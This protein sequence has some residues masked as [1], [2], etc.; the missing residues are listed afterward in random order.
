M[1]AAPEQWQLVGDA[2]ELYERYLVPPVTLPW[3]AD[4]VDRVGVE[5]GD[6]VLD[7]A[8]GTGAVARLAAAR[9]GEAGRVAGS[10]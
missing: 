3:A 4:L 7:V 2:A 5:P 6:R 1:T 8:C 10:T 9:V